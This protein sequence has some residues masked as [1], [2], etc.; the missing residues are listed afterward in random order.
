MSLDGVELHRIDSLDEALA[1]KRWLGERRPILA[2][3]TETSGLKP[4]KDHV[5]LIQFGD[6]M[7]GWTIRWDRWAG[8]ALEVFKDYSG[9]YV[10]HNMKFDLQMIERWC[11]V[12]IPWSR[13]HDTAIMARLID[14][15]GPRG[16]KSIAP[17]LIDRKAAVGEAMLEKAMTEHGWTWATIPYEVPV[18]SVYAAMDTVLTARL[19][20]IMYPRTKQ[21]CPLAYDL[22]RAF[23]AAVMR[24][25]Q[26]GSLIDRPYAEE[27]AESFDRYVDEAGQWCRTNYGVE[28]GSNQKVIDRMQQDGV[29]FRKRTRGGALSLDAEV[30]ESITHPLA[31][32][33]LQRRKVQ[34]I[35]STYLRNFLLMGAD[36][37]IVRPIMDTQGAATGRM[38]M[39]L[40]QTLPRR[41]ETNP[42]AIT[43]RNCI[44][45][46]E[47]NVLMMCD[48]D[49]IEMRVL[50]HLASDAGLAQAFTEGDFF[51]NVARQIFGDPTIVKGDER[52]QRTKNAMYAKAYGAGLE[53]FA[54]TAGATIEQAQTVWQGIDQQFPGIKSLQ[55]QVEQVATERADREGRPYVLS[56]LTRQPYYPKDDDRAYALV[57]YLIQGTAASVLKMKTVELALAGVGDYLTLLVHDEVIGDVP[58]EHAHEVA[59]IMQQTMNDSTL[60]TVPITA[61]VELGYRWGEK[62]SVKLHELEVA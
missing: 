52:R 15:T 39:E 43:V 26:R 20:E 60:F 44:R 59:Q 31:Q 29:E 28:P 37:N 34:K 55:R 42:L 32:V 9:E 21:T 12:T 17:M 53:K 24:M 27:T 5:R 22:E 45:A 51:A 35:A 11:G 25:E 49:Q 2:I 23:T 38:S 40:L 3:D 57:N 1:F 33:V 30:L 41:S 18:Y 7:Q 8:V 46:R 56:P 50:A 58:V 62:G 36:D 48:F 61:A 4:W 54:L 19:W 10:G 13:V 14:P 6:R 16:L 47:G